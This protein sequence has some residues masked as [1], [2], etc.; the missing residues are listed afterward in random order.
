MHLHKEYTYTFCTHLEVIYNF[1][2]LAIYFENF[3]PYVYIAQPDW[4][5]K[6]HNILDMDKA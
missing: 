4:L 1:L 6:V 2:V 5:Q 3:F